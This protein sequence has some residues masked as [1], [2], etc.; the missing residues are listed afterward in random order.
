MN[1]VLFC[2]KKSPSNC[3][4]SDSPGPMASSELVTSRVIIKNIPKYYAEDK[5]REFVQN[6]IGG[7]VTDVRIPKDANGVSRKFAFIGLTDV[8][9]AQKAISRLD[10]TFLDTCRLNVSAAY[11]PGSSAIP[12]PWSRHTAGSSAYDKSQM[13]KNKQKQKEEVKQVKQKQK[14]G[15]VKVK[16]LNKDKQE[17]LSVSS[18]R[19]GVATWKDDITA[20]P[21]KK[22]KSIITIKAV[23]PTKAGVAANR[24]HVEF[25][26]S[27]DE[28]VESENS[29]EASSNG[30]RE[31]KDEIQEDEDPLAWLKNKSK[32]RPD[33][34]MEDAET[35]D[36]EESE[37]DGTNKK[38]KTN[39]NEKIDEKVDENEKLSE[40]STGLLGDTGRLMIL[41]L[42]YSM[43]DDD[44]RSYLIQYGELSEVHVCRDEVF[45]VQI[46]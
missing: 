7:S 32:D 8:Q 10:N 35:E 26:E 33:V 2:A 40:D 41:N 34:E 44:L 13:E 4:N 38:G 18:K 16:E 28:E 14:E 6:A 46:M 36:N 23:V 20:P 12:R 21:L 3:Q 31:S 37:S 24:S 15:E 22:I 19:R 1:P 42:P 17:F 43:T 27:D 25:A 30:G 9:N 11:A 5:L 39:G 29:I 45:T